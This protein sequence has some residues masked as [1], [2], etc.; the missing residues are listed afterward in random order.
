MI[1]DPDAEYVSQLYAR[2]KHLQN[3]ASSLEFAAQDLRY[4]A[5]EIEDRYSFQ[6][7]CVGCGNR[8]SCRLAGTCGAPD[9]CQ[10]ARDLRDAPREATA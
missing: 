10:T 4:Q 9:R 1:S 7:P 8:H 5:Q 3:R 2:A 6:G